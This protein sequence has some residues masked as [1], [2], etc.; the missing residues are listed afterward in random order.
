MAK[1]EW[2]PL[3]WC[4]MSLIC[5]WKWTIGWQIWFYNF[6]S[7]NIGTCWHVTGKSSKPIVFC[8]E[9]LI[10]WKYLYFMLS[11]I[12]FSDPYATYIPE[13]LKRNIW[14]LILQVLKVIDFFFSYS[15]MRLLPSLIWKTLTLDSRGRCI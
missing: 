3:R 11:L 12:H 1:Y 4:F 7:R 14:L 9:V 15:A 10:L 5:L 8:A 13:T 2:H 6:E